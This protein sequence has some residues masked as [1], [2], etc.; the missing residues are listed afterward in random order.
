ML[1]FIENYYEVTENNKEVLRQLM[2]AEDV[3]CTYDGDPV[4]I[5]KCLWTGYVLGNT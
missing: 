5:D 4:S 1:D 3:Q 2:I